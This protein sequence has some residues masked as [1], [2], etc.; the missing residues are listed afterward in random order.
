V[1]PSLAEEE[2]RPAL[3]SMIFTPGSRPDLIAKAA[4]SGADA[5][6]VDLEDAVAESAK[7]AARSGLCNLPRSE[8]PWY[9]RVNGAG[10]AHLWDDLMAAGQC[11]IA[12]IVLPKADD[13]R[14]LQQLDGALTVLERQARRHLGAIEII[15]LIENAA[16]VLAA[17]DVL[18]CTRRVK[19]V[20]FGSGEQGD[21]VTDLGCEWTADGAAL[22]TARSLVVLAAR[23]SGVQPMDAVFMDF[24]NLD[25]LRVECRLARRTG[26]AGK[27]AIH[28][29]QLPVIHEV[30]TPGPEEIAAQLRILEL[31]DQALARGSSSIDVDGHMVDYA[32]AARARSILARARAPEGQRQTG[33]AGG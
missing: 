30:F 4:A 3:R 26:Y 7:Q 9:V 18:S 31:F 12:G 20:M 17:R 24:R 16:G 5:V 1:T 33:G 19:T 11:D 27:V 28:P 10:T 22:L 23:A 2:T 6:I 15:P 21:L 32:V 13:V 14:L 29:A 8:V 25:A